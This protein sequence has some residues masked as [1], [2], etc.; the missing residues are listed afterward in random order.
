MT[1]FR[2]KYHIEL[3]Q[4]I[5]GIIEFPGIFVKILSNSYESLFGEIKTIK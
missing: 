3:M 5:N 2:N 4:L 1:K